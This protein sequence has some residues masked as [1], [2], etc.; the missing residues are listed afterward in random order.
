[1]RRRTSFYLP[2]LSAQHRRN[3]AAEL[4]RQGYRAEV[5]GDAV[6]TDATYPVVTGV[7]Q[8]VIRFTNAS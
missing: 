5:V 2:E 6:K 4:V 3:L 1:M 7:Y 8:Y